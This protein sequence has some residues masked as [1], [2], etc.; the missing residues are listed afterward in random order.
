M[1][2]SIFI[3]LAC[4]LV[5]HWYV[6]FVDQTPEEIEQKG[7]YLKWEG[8]RHSIKHGLGTALVF[9]LLLDGWIDAVALGLVDFLI[10]YH[11]DWAKIQINK[12][13][14]YTIDKPEFWAWLGADQLAH[15]L[16]YLWLVWIVF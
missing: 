12:R 9:W 8:V 13:W 10:H 3:I 6:D 1:F 11:I 7:C 5:K 15:G 16:T 14:N 2:D 4:L